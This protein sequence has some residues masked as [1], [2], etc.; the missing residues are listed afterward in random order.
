MLHQIAGGRD[1]A[2]EKEWD[3]RLEGWTKEI[4]GIVKTVG[5]DGPSTKSSARVKEKGKSV[6]KAKAK[7]EEDGEDSC[8]SCA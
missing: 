3:E 4:G 8:G 1:G 6:K 2:T 7:E 5:G